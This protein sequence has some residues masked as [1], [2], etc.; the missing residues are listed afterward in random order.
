MES[1]LEKLSGMADST[2]QNFKA[3][4]ESFDR[5]CQ[6][7]YG[8]SAEEKILEIPQDEDSEYEVL[9]DWVNWLS[10][11]IIPSTI[12]TK[13]SALR[14]YFHYRGIKIYKED[15]RQEIK[16][17]KIP[18][19]EKHPLGL[20]EIRKIL[21]EANFKK[22]ALYL[23][24]LSSGM[25]VGEAVQLKKKHFDTSEKQFMI[26][27]SANSTKTK[28]G[29]T[30]F[31]S[32]E[33]SDAVKPTLKRIEGDDLVFA[34]NNKPHYA[35]C[36]EGMTFRR[37]LKNTGLLES[38]ESSRTNKITIHSFRSYFFTK[39]TRKHG[40]NYAHKM[41]G[42]GGY[43]MQYD[44]MTIEEKRAMYLELEPDL[45]IDST[46]R[47]KRIID[48][49]DRKIADIEERFL[50]INKIQD[51]I[52]KGQKLFAKLEIVRGEML[53]SIKNHDDGYDKLVLGANKLVEELKV[54]TQE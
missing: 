46:E 49:K 30:V 16:L 19:E 33:A 12:N 34:K 13:F 35:V 10:K 27:I 52:D 32:K 7:K 41:T 11:S 29:R 1:Y 31:I 54:I 5:F 26:K 42:H 4:Y 51:E 18:K 3:T 21:G 23:T 22:K 39:A 14:G 50:R 25:R 37:I 8:H 20:E 9:Q 47:Q 24:L 45:I 48:Q 36:C 6:E 53:D 38:Y 15:I 28:A 44:R 17:P 40:E 2:K 43:L